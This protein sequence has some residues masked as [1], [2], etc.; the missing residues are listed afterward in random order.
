MIKTKYLLII[1]LTISFILRVWRIDFPQAYVFDEV[2]YP[3]TA[4]EYLKNNTAAWEWWTT[5]PKGNS[6]AWVNPPLAQE[7]MAISMKVFGSDNYWS[8]RL[9][10]VFLGVLSI[11]L[12]YLISMTLFKNQRVALITAFLFSLDGLTLVQSRTGMLDI[13]L[14]TFLLASVYFILTKHFFWSALFLSFAISTKWT[15]LYIVPLYAWL[16]IKNRDYL[17][18]I[19]YLIIIPIT[20][21]LI[22]IPFFLSGHDFSQFIELL[23]QEW[24]YHIHLK[25]THNFSSPWWAW[26]LNFYSVWYYVQYYPQNI[27]SNIFAGG[28]TLIY[29]LGSISLAVSIWQLLKTRLQSLSIIIA[30]FLLFWLPW[31]LSP[32]IMF[33]YYFI[34]A[35]PFL[36][37]SLGYQLD[38]LYSKNKNLITIL[39]VIILILSVLNYPFWVGIPLP[40]QWAVIFFLT[41]F[42]NNP[43]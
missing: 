25:A 17:K 8:F 26:P 5:A 38:K 37:L 16:L 15:G 22:Y 3:F 19:W 30:G 28:N 23:R 18:S 43:F 9:P 21:L 35:L 42:T 4:G 6:Y 41:N 32:R 13:Y 10:G 40:R 14:L 29:W 7:I 27:M 2:Y 33:L 11:Y 39:L 12:L 31:S 24:W 1:I 36:I 20:Y 34:P